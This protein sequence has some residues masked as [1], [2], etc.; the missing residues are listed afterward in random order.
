MADGKGRSVTDRCAECGVY[1]RRIIT[2]DGDEARLCLNCNEESL[3]EAVS[4]LREKL[5]LDP[6]DEV[7]AIAFGMAD[8]LVGTPPADSRRDYIVAAACLYVASIIEDDRITQPELAAVANTSTSGIRQSYREIYDASGFEAVFGAIKRGQHNPGDP[9]PDIDL[10][11]FRAHL[12]ASNSRKAVKS[13]VSDVRRFAVWYDGSALPTPDDVER[14]L[15]HLADDGF[16]PATI[17]S[18]YQNV[19]QYFKW[20]NLDVFDAGDVGLEA[21]LAVA[22]QQKA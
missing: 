12:D 7:C 16:A 9:H 17:E 18:R 20:A 8:A 3:I 11:G 2:A 4:E 5:D 14:W 13:T 19:S 15:H 22:Y 10:E 21:A 1:N 6:R